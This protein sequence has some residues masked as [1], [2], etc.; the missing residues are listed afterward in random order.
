MRQFTKL[1]AVDRPADSRDADRLAYFRLCLDAYLDAERGASGSIDHHL[2]VA[3]QTIRLRFAGDALVDRIMPAF[4]HLETDGSPNPDLTICL[5]DSASTRRE[6]PLLISSLVRLLKMTWLDER[7]I[8]GEIFDYN[9]NRIR[10]ALHGYEVDM[11]S[12]VD[13][14]ENLGIFWISDAAT[15]PYYETGAPLRS[16]LQWWFARAGRQIVH[17]GATGTGTGGILLA[18]KGGSGKSTAALTCLDSSLSYAGD[19]YTLITTD[20]APF[21]HSL[22]NTAKVKGAAD[23]ARFPLLVDRVSN[24]DRI[25]PDGEKPMMF[26]HEYAPMKTISGFPLKAIV[27]PRYIAGSGPGCKVIPISPDSAFKALAPST[28]TQL[29]G[30][31]ADSMRVMSTLVRQVPSFLVGFGEDRSEIARTLLNLLATHQ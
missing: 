27:F 2:R 14:E 1:P 26:I 18:G 7:G 15:L 9:S 22:Y 24:Q 23:L 30:A 31:G 29:P 10:T 11:L 13:L 16:I 12:S 19:D 20:P 6:L 4:A 17:A 3:D 28:I 21:V 25:G 8:R 5:W